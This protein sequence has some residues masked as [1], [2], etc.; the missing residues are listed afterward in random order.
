MHDDLLTLVE[1]VLRI[2][3]LEQAERTR[4]SEVAITIQQLREHVED[5]KSVTVPNSKRIKISAKDQAKTEEDNLLQVSSARKDSPI[6]SAAIV[7]SGPCTK[8][9][10]HT[11]VAA[12]GIPLKTMV[13]SIASQV[14]QVLLREASSK[15]KVTTKF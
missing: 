1:L 9:T 13:Q 5:R 10:G 7:T 2:R 12:E 11:D 4:H 15:G 6:P 14:V 3:D 8:R